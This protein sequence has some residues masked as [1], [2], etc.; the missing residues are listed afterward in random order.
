MP[1]IAV[2]C[3]T[4]NALNPAA[5]AR[6]WADMTGGSVRDTGNGF[7]LV[8]PGNGTPLL[9]Q[10]AE[11]PAKESGWVHLDCTVTDRDAAEREICRQGGRMVER[12]NRSHVSRSCRQCS[13]Q[14]IAR[15]SRP[16]PR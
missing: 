7:V 6:F 10:Q 13:H 11:R 1:L 15:R 12:R 5:L 3:V 14:R 4:I 8:E 16:A 2:N 9:F